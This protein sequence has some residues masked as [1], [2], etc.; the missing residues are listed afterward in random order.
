MPILKAEIASATKEAPSTVEGS[1]VW[2]PTDRL[3]GTVDRSIDDYAWCE[4]GS[5]S[6]GDPRNASLNP[7]W[8]VR[9]VTAKVLE[10]SNSI[11]S[12][13]YNKKQSFSCSLQTFYMNG[14]C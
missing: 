14:V 13:S 12:S 1:T 2:P 5:A 10:Q 6:T 7:F 4:A 9:R 11:F 8:G 3:V